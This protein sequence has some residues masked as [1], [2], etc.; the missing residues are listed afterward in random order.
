MDG[1][2]C[3]GSVVSV[4]WRADLSPQP[5]ESKRGLKSAGQKI[6]PVGSTDSDGSTGSDASQVYWFWCF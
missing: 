2:G 6:A 4:V 3:D 1:N 5:S